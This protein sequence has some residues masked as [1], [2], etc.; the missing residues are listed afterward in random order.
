MRTL[1]KIGLVAFVLIALLAIVT[2]V[3]AHVREGKL[4]QIR[5]GMRKRDV[6]RLLGAGQ[7]SIMSPACEK[8]PP[9]RTQ[10][11]YN[12]NPSLWYGRLEDT[13]VVCYVGDV[14]CDTSRV[15]L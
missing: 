10:Y 4:E 8:C 2:G 11:A 15:G 1:K 5:P 9:G 6:E 3:T 13:L 12:A 7:P 14:V